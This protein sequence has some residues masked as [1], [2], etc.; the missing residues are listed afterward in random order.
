MFYG[1]DSYDVSVW[2]PSKA[3]YM[4]MTSTSTYH[5]RFSILEE[6]IFSALASPCTAEIKMWE[7]AEGDVWVWSQNGPESTGTVSGSE[8]RLNHWPCSWPL[9]CENPLLEHTGLDMTTHGEVREMSG[10]DTQW[11]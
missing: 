6:F 8:L 5:T 9:S 10:P 3:T 11:E 2:T 1:I 7:R 4:V